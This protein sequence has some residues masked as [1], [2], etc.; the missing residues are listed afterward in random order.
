VFRS[1]KGIEL[2]SAD[3]S[4]TP[5]TL[6]SG[7]TSLYPVSFTPD[8][9]SLL[10]EELNVGTGIDLSMVDSNGGT[11][12][13]LLATPR[14]EAQPAVS[15]D[16][17]WLAYSSD[18]T[19]RSEVYVRPFTEPLPETRWQISSAGGNYPVW[20]RTSSEL[21]YRANDERIMIVPYRATET[22]FGAG[23]ERRWSEVTHWALGFS[24][25]YDVA[26]DGS[27]LLVLSGRGGSAGIPPASPL[28][29]I[30][31]FHRELDRRLPKAR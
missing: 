30:L 29:V 21:M 5:R 27:R 8:G 22:L 23:K 17:K 4:G 1:D 2:V 15:P 3:G 12:R 24:R 11:P 28:T 6:V 10:Y 18:E 16:G 19:G 26:S 20:S 31:N 14:N 9:K 13:R 25:P 7:T